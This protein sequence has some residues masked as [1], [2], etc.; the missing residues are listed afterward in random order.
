MQF[1]FDDI[2]VWARMKFNRVLLVGWDMLL[3]EVL[4]IGGS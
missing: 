3:R 4:P 2:N 1:L